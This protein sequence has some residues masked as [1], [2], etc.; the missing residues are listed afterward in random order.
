MLTIALEPE[1][2]SIFCQTFP[3][4][5]CREIAE[6][7]SRYM[8]ADLGGMLLIILYLHLCLV[9]NSS[10]ETYHTR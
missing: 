4:P 6:I 9:K 8:V 7:G 1:A 5:G 3:S 10:G 2:A